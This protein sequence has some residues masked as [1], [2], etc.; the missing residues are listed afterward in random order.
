MNE[1]TFVLTSRYRNITYGTMD[2]YDYPFSALALAIW[3]ESSA[4]WLRHGC[5]PL[6]FG[7]FRDER[8]TIKEVAEP[9]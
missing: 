1:N 8:V 7:E 5:S 2:E 9:A 3:I 4:W 6:S